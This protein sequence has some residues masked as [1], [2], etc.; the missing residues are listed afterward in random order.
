PVSRFSGLVRRRSSARAAS[1]GLCRPPR[2]RGDM[3]IAVLD[4][5]QDTIRTLAC[6]PKV[7]GHHVTIWRADTKDVDEL[8]RRLKDTEALCLIRERPPIR[9]PLLDR[10][11]KLRIISQVGVF[12]HVDVE[13]CTRRGV[14]MSSSSLPGRPS[15]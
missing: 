1:I 6:Y 13:A 2:R 9:G 7:A 3:N 11:A 8:A 5:Y 10:L 4:D 14:I 12:P 15:Y